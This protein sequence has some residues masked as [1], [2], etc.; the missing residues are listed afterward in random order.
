MPSA[1]RRVV[2]VVCTD[3]FAG[4]ERYICDVSVEL[5]RRGWDVSVIGGDPAAMARELGTAVTHR[6]AVGVAAAVREVDSAR[7]RGVLHVHMTQAEVAA[8][9]AV[10]TWGMPCFTT[11]H[12]A[13]PRGSSAAI[14][15]ASPLLRR[16][17][18]DQLAISRFVASR[19]G[20][21]TTLLPNGVRERPAHTGGSR[22]VVM[23][24]RLDLE[25]Q[26]DIGL[27]AWALSGL[28]EDGWR[29]QV[30]GRGAQEP[31]LRALAQELGV[32]SSVEFLGFVTDTAGLLDRADVFFAS[33]PE[34]PFGL[35]VAE[36]MAAALP[37]VAARGG[38][39]VETIADPDLLFPP[40]DPAAAARVLRRVAEDDVLRRQL[41][42]QAQAR[43][44]REFSIAGHV[45]QL[46]EIY[47]GALR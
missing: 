9:L 19:V 11:R 45:D 17:F 5:A 39:H 42:A 6:P 28:A 22:S 33:A 16:R 26:T 30:A 25:K 14:R 4:V 47:E 40:G 46:S 12:F 43:Q 2:H 44:R 7:G 20:E 18:R 1:D 29:L 41:G 23:M 34:E 8:A 36:A 3:A 38:A 32:A 10:R 24:Q 13:A 21:P 27:H 31:A 15:A 35:A 37:V